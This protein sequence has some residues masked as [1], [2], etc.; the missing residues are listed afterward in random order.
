MKKSSSGL[1][2]EGVRAG[3]GMSGSSALGLGTSAGAR[4]G[5]DEDPVRDVAPPVSPARAGVVLA[6]ALSGRSPAAGLVGCRVCETAFGGGDVVVIGGR[7]EGAVGVEVEVE[8]PA[9]PPGVEPSPGA[10]V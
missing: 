5:R 7:E 8:A 10:D 6:C 4:A 2:P 3:E 1:A 9:S